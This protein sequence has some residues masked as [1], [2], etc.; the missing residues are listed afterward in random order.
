[1]KC[2]RC[3]REIPENSI[4]CN[5]CGHKQLTESNE[6]R[7]PPPK[8]RGRVWS[9][10]VQIDGERHLIKGSTEDEYYRNARAFKDN[11]IKIEKAAP[12]IALGTVIDNYL[13]DHTNVIS[14]S[15]LN[16]Y[17]SYRR[18]RF[19]NYMDESISKINWQK[20]VNDEAANYSP[21]TIR[22][23]WSLVTLSLEYAEHQKPEVKLPKKRKSKREWLDFE[24]IQSFT[25]ALRGKP[26][27]LG[28]LL[29][30]QG[31]RRSEIL[32]LKAE[33]ID[34]E[35]G[36]IHVHGS[37]VIGENNKPVD[38][39][40]NKTSAST[41]TVH[42]V[43]PRI[44]ELVKNTDGRLVT[45][46]PTTLYGSINKLCAKVGIPT[47]GVHGLRHSYCSLARH[48]GWDEMTVMREGGWD[49]PT[50]VHEVYTHLAEQDANA[51]VQ[52]MKD[53]YETRMGSESQKTDS[54]SRVC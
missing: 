37:T 1:M 46:N 9:A 33:D 51:D 3:K 8:K 49:D 45:T 40:Y 6:T 50:V 53:F 16:Q 52:K 39:E 43:I 26:Y 54:M 2:K 27:E 14:P 5:W 18:T 44:T 47:V 32:Y 36:I 10:Q 17:R 35:R 25:S 13:N 11:F 31:L 19:K 4:F 21:K 29:A 28:A 34:T 22:N 15:T 23:A 12:K 48:L 42:I 41:R 30:L 20:M 38:K 7:V 24:Q